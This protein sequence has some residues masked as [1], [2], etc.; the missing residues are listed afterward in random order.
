MSAMNS[1]FAFR[2]LRAR[3]GRMLAMV[4]AFVLTATTASWAAVRTERM[5]Q[6]GAQVGGPFLVY[7]YSTGTATMNDTA[8]NFDAGTY[9]STQKTS[10]GNALMLVRQGDVAPNPTDVWWDTLWRTRR[11]WTVTNTTAATI[12]NG[13]A[14]VTFDATTDVAN[15]WMLATGADIRAVSGGATPATL[16]FNLAAAPSATTTVTMA[17]PSL[18]AATSQSLCLY[19][20][21][22]AATTSTSVT[23]P[24]AGGVVLY[25]LVSN[26]TIAD[27]PNW[28]SDVPPGLPSGATRVLSA[29]QTVTSLNAAPGDAVTAADVDASVPAG[30]LLSIFARRSRGV[31]TAGTFAE[32]QFSVPSGTNVDVRTYYA[33]HEAAGYRF[34]VAVNGSI[35]LPDFEPSSICTAAGLTQRCGLMR[36]TNVTS[37][38]TVTLRFSPVVS[39][40]GSALRR[41]IWNAIELRTPGSPVTVLSATG[42]NRREGLTASS[43]TW[44]SPVVDTGSAATIFGIV[45]PVLA[46]ASSATGRPVTAS[47]LASGSVLAAGND[48]ARTGTAFVSTTVAQP[49]WEVDLGSNQSVRAVD[50]YTTAYAMSDVTVFVSPTSLSGYASPAAAI[51]AGVPNVV[52]TGP[53]ASANMNSVFPSGTTGQYVRIWASGTSSLTLAEVEITGPTP[54]GAT[55]QV[56]VSTSSSGPWTFVGPDGTSATS[57]TSTGAFPYSF[58]ANRYYRAQVT[59][60]SASG[61]ASPLLDFIRTTAGL[62]TLPRTADGF[63]QYSAPNIGVNW[64]VRIKTSMGAITSAATATLHPQGVATWGASQISG[65]LDR[66]AASCCVGNAPFFT[67]TAATTSQTPVALYDVG[68]FRNISVISDRADDIPA[69]HEQ[70]VDIALSPTMRVQVPLRRTASSASIPTNIAIG[71]VA[72]QS[73]TGFGG[74]AARG[75]DNNTNGDYFGGSSVMHTNFEVNP[76]W[77][78]DLGSQRLVNSV[79]VYNRTDCC[80]NRLTGFHILVSANPLPATLAA[81]LVAPGVTSL[82]YSGGAFS[83]PQALTFP[84]GATGRYVRLWS[85]N[86]DYLHVAEVRVIGPS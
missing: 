9:S 24:A 32:F 53:I 73:S 34:N 41:P 10:D 33:D 51:T 17:V 47:P 27:T 36:F 45:Q 23:L 49:F 8:I 78:V 14:T 85:T 65:H 72:S 56:A 15:G 61:V 52:F 84:S 63:H 50:V 83:T 38:G 6:V 66:S 67:T 44:T 1:G 82:Q 16:A 86:T 62:T 70:I 4:L 2:R 43:G 64:T 25:R 11:C 21:N 80:S 29:G 5:A 3:R 79:E 19:W 59:F 46:S 20:G 42:G 22:P 60:Q 39:G 54:T 57:Y 18:A 77:Q 31:N 37:T 71:K 58:D 30:T 48:G 69:D 35:T 13:R 12:T 40:V 76:W 28:S 55:A 26:T 68:G 81:A 75:N 7:D 74:I